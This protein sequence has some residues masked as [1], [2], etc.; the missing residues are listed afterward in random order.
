M[1]DAIELVRSELLEARE[2]GVGQSVQAAMRSADGKAE[3]SIP[4]VNVRLGGSAGWQL[5]TMQTVTVV[6]GPSVDRDGKSIKVNAA[7]DEIKE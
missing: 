1:A 7:S 5:E 6:F 3:F 2:K 4:I